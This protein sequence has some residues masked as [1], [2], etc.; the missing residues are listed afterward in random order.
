MPI[1]STSRRPT[2]SRRGLE[3]P[4]AGVRLSPFIDARSLYVVSEDAIWNGLNL[5]DAAE[6]YAVTAHSAS[7]LAAQPTRHFRSVGKG[8]RI[9]LVA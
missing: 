3:E 4:W 5:R 2:N 6:F 8:H 9:A 1:R 7:N